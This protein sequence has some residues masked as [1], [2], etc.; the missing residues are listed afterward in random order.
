MT[1]DEIKKDFP[2]FCRENYP[3]LYNYFRGYAGYLKRIHGPSYMDASAVVTMDAIYNDLFKRQDK[4]VLLD[5]FFTVLKVMND[6][7]NPTQPHEGESGWRYGHD[8]AVMSTSKDI[9]PSDVFSIIRSEIMA[10]YRNLH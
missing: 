10:I 2:G 4:L 5:Q 8:A 1:K 9:W 7:L 6:F 3:E